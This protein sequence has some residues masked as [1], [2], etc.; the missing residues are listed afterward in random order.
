MHALQ[1]KIE[2]RTI[3]KTYLALVLGKV[4][5][6]SGYIESY[7]GRDPNDRKKM[8]T[9]EPVN[10]KLAKT[11]FKKI[12]EINNKYTLLEVDLLTG[13]THQIRVHLSSIG[14]PIIGDKIYGNGKANTE[15]LEQY[16]LT[17]QWLHAWKLQFNLF[18]KDFA[19][20]GDVKDD[21]KKFLK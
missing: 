17:R 16:G 10:P 8:T 3:E 18:G 1:L 9:R 2:K 20:E 7:I 4:A 21:L 12:R 6:E 14:H 15:A 19:F 11:R 13:R 5:E